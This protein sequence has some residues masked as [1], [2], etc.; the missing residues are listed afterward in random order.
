MRFKCS[1]GGLLVVFSWMYFGSISLNAQSST[2][3][4]QA[5]QK[6]NFLGKVLYVAA[7]PDDENTAVISYFSN[8][9]NAET[10]YFSL[11]RGGG[12]QNLI[13]PE[14]RDELGLIRTYELIE[15]RKVDGGKQFFSTAI[16]FGYSKSSEETFFRMG[17]EY[18]PKANI[19]CHQSLPT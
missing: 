1:N 6:F 18:A 16:D 2:D 13:G 11:T 17:E 12:G 4:Y 7:H 8:F 15:A 19:G 10:A 3:I 5:L 14:L 9:R